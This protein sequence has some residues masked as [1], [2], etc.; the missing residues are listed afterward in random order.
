MKEGYKKTELGLIPK[1]WK[2]VRFNTIFE[3]ITKK[4]SEDNKNILTISAQ[5]GLINQEKFFNKTVA[6]K[7]TKNY[8]LLENGDFAYNKSYSNGY[9]MGAIKKL[10]YYDKG[11]VSPLYICFRLVDFDS[12]SEFYKYFFE[13]DIFDKCIASIAQEG[14]RNHGLLNVGISEFFNLLIIKPPLAEQQTIAEILSTVDSQIDDTDKLIEKTKE[15]KK[16]LM[17]R[18]LTKGIGHSEF[19]KSEVGEIPVEWE[20]RQIGDIANIRSSKRVYQNEYM[21][22]GIPFYRSKEIIELSKNIEPTTE[23]YISEE[24]YLEFVNKFGAP[25]KGD[26]LITSVGSVG[27]TWVSDGRNFYYKDG[28][29][30]QIE[31]NKNINTNFIS[32]V[33]NSDYLKKQY[34]G[35]SNGSA[36]IALTLEKLRKLIIALPSL[37]EQ[38]E[39]VKI[40]SSV[41]I[42]IQE[43][44][45][46]K[47]KLE[48]LKKGLM[49]QLLTGKIRVV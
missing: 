39:I 48:E 16:G 40:L 20:V 2:L 9:P 15:L 25:K 31:S 6:S 24:K 47:T 4:N 43:Y 33:F 27:M 35:Q 46:K 34:L 5:Y 36:Q 22:K 23:L 30:T 29:L 49:Q 45:N 19:K 14:A 28:N 12:S 44:K 18:L 32:Y 8:F 17:Q 1:E 21:D 3:R 42:Q 7:N 11:I 26:L 41:D 13:Y 37:D 10:E 38:K